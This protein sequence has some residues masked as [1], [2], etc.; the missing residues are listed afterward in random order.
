MLFAHCETL[1]PLATLM[2][3]FKPDVSKLKQ[4]QVVAGEGVGGLAME[5]RVRFV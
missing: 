2:G 1:V 3:L 5:L 4:Q